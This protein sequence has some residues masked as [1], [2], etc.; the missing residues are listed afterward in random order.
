[1]TWRRRQ[2]FEIDHELLWLAISSAAFL[3]A[4][5]WLKLGFPRP[6][7]LFHELTR[8]ACL[9]CGATRCFLA[10]CE[11]HFASAFHWNP[12]VFFALFGI[13]LFDLYALVVL[14]FNLPRLR[15]DQV[16]PATAAGIRLAAVVAAVANWIY[17]LRAGI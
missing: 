17:L 11:G 2:P 5:F 13:L 4:V 12:L 9:T 8:H 7:C 3:C 1:M 10:L 16:T 6:V 15:F 14:L